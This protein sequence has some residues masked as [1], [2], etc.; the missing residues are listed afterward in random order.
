MSG[1]TSFS[2]VE[3]PA[4]T[5]TGRKH[6]QTALKA[7]LDAWGHMSLEDDSSEISPAPAAAATAGMPKTLGTAL[8][9]LTSLRPRILAIMDAQPFCVPLESLDIMHPL[10]GG[11]KNAHVMFVGP[12]ER[13]ER[14]ENR[15]LREVC[16]AC[17]TLLR[18]DL[19]SDL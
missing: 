8:V 1:F 18:S 16:G 14:E 4:N 11:A 19:L 9:L 10:R 7:A 5:E 2:T 6:C 12:G 13:E 15:K 3:R 17:L